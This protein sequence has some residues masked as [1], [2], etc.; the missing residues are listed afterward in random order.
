M[1]KM[2]KNVAN[3]LVLWASAHEGIAL[4]VSSPF[5]GQKRSKLLGRYLIEY[6]SFF[7]L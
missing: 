6:L 3:M 5:S 2:L 7:V 4:H 1:N